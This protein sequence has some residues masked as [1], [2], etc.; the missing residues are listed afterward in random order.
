MALQNIFYSES[1]IK[2]CHKISKKASMP[3]L[4]EHEKLHVFFT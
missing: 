3:L 4:P 2:S 1:L